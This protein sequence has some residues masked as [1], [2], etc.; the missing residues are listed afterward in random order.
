[1]DNQKKPG[2][3]LSDEELEGAAGGTLIPGNQGDTEKPVFRPLTSTLP[4]TPGDKELQ[5]VR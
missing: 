3:E 1:M 5:N 2:V 4:G